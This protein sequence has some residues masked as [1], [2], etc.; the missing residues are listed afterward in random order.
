[1][2]RISFPI[3]IAGALA[4]ICIS[5]SS[6]VNAQA[7]PLTPLPPPTTDCVIATPQEKFLCVDQEYTVEFTNCVGQGEISLRHGDPTNLE[8]ADDPACSDVEFA[9]GECTF[10]P[11]KEGIF[12]FSAKDDKGKETFTGTF[13]VIDCSKSEKPAKVSSTPS[14]S[15]PQT[16]KEAIRKSNAKKRALYDIAA[17]A[18]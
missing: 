1:M 10:I 12:S 17:F 15:N 9:D 13:K 16:V 14:S 11:D 6:N 18:L 4:I 8:T 7:T 3:L 2:A 5:T